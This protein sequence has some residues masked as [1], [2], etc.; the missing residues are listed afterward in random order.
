VLA[1]YLNLWNRFPEC[2]CRNFAFVVILSFGP[3]FLLGLLCCY[4]A[5][6]FSTAIIGLIRLEF[7]EASAELNAV[8]D[9]FFSLT[10]RLLLS[11]S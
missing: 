9:V 7:D 10:F 8:M 2:F 3:V 11:F 1:L 4:W 5:Q 6:L